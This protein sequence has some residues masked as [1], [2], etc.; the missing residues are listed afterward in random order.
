MDEI[1]FA[2]HGESEAA[3]AGLVGGDTPLTACGHDEARALG[4]HLRSSS[5]GVC[6]TNSVGRLERWCEEPSW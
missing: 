3:A 1:A 4:R 6:V 5:I 2:R